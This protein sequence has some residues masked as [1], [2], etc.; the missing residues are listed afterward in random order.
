[1]P[2]S[3]RG[4]NNS[5]K[6][7]LSPPGTSPPIDP[8]A[9]MEMQRQFGVVGKLPA[10]M[11]SHHHHHNQHAA[12]NMNMNMNM[13]GINGINVNQMM[14]A[15]AA[16]MNGMNPMNHG[17]NQ[18][19]VNMNNLAGMGGINPNMNM[20]AMNQMNMNAMNQVNMNV[21][22]VNMG[23]MNA[24]HMN[25]LDGFGGGGAGDGNDAASTVHGMGGIL[26]NG[27]GYS[28]FPLQ[29]HDGVQTAGAGHPPNSEA[30]MLSF[31][32]ANMQM[33]RDQRQHFALAKLSQ[34]TQQQSFQQLS[35]P[36]F[37]HQNNVDSSA[38]ST[39]GSTSQQHQQDEQRQQQQQQQQLRDA[40]SVSMKALSVINGPPM[41]DAKGGSG[42]QKRSFEDLMSSAMP[43]IGTNAKPMLPSEI[44]AAEQPSS[45]KR[46][47]KT[48][49]PSDMPRRAL[50]AYNIFF[51][52]QRQIILK[53]IDAKEKK[54]KDDKNDEDGGGTLP[55]VSSSASL[56][57]SSSKTAGDK[58]AG[59]QSSSTD[60]KEAA[61]SSERPNVLNRTFFPK[62][63]KRPH[64]K[65]HGKIG[66]VALARTV[67]KRWKELPDDKRKYYQD[68]AA[69][70]KK[71]HKE[72]MAEYKERKAAESIVSIKSPQG[73]NDDDNMHH[74]QQRQQQGFDDA[75]LN[76]N[77]GGNINLMNMHNQQSQSQSSQMPS[78]HA[79]EVQQR[80][81]REMMDM[82]PSNAP[83]NTAAAAN[84]A[85]DFNFM[86][87]QRLQNA[88]GH[89]GP[90][91]M[92]QQQH[93]HQQQQQLHSQSQQQQQQQQQQQSSA[94]I[95]GGS[96]SNGDMFVGTQRFNPS[97][98]GAF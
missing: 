39:A 52:E 56:Q 8:V 1:L 50:S 13:G 57:S 34:D 10:G 78:M 15:G 33:Q 2:S 86:M 49:K 22:N 90:S 27:G 44:E 80:L 97:S 76:G 3:S 21:M 70:D 19:N 60:P 98:F 69:E 87:Q 26:N 96:A 67:S 25:N 88:F 54:E 48:K 82:Q 18:V 17:M 45:D 9:M 41:M 66:L 46:P 40:S 28:A 11:D 36:A 95:Q 89:N 79:Q 43:E 55:A 29:S 42:G 64:R 12:M 24:M 16:P 6:I 68:L 5:D 75:I 47:R 35:T 72:A 32:Q 37:A 59:E 93:H 77:A 62:R 20:N 7:S 73:N 53:E 23:G 31:L 84:S 4:G 63:V 85:S 58:K 94:Q 38:A 51:S 91:S 61:A 30:A 92:Q 81:L 65:V 71:R 14:A 83:S 74:L